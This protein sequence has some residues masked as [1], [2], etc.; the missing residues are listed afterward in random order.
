MRARYSARPLYAA[1]NTTRKR[2]D[3]KN[4][5]IKSAAHLLMAGSGCLQV[6]Q[7][8]PDALQLRQ[9]HRWVAAWAVARPQGTPPVGV[10]DGLQ[11]LRTREV[12]RQGDI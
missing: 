5:P 10:R 12:A 9:H 7:L 11:V 3:D 4:A 8:R 6:F 2:L 1:Q